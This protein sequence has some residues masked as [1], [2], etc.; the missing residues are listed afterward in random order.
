MKNSKIVILFFLVVLNLVFSNLLAQSQQGVLMQTKEKTM[1]VKQFEKKS[2]LDSNSIKDYYPVSLDLETLTKGNGNKLKIA[3][4]QLTIEGKQKKKLHARCIGI[5]GKIKGDPLGSVIISIR[6]KNVMGAIYTGGKT[7]LIK[8]L[9]EDEYYLVEP[10]FCG[11]EEG[12]QNCVLKSDIGNEKRILTPMAQESMPGSTLSVNCKLRFLIMYTPAVLEDNSD[13]YNFI[14]TLFFQAQNAL[15]LS[16]ISGGEWEL[17]YAGL[18]QY[19]EVNDPSIS[20]GRF[21]DRDRFVNNNDGYMDEVHVLRQKYNAD[22]CVLMT[23]CQYPGKCGGVAKTIAATSANVAFCLVHDIMDAVAFRH[24]V[25]HLLGGRHE[26]DGSTYPYAYSHGYK[27]TAAGI[28]HQTIMATGA[29]TTNNWSNP[30][31]LNNGVPMGTYSWN[32]CARVLDQT[33]PY[34]AKFLQP[35]S[36]LTFSTDSEIGDL[37]IGD[38]IS[39]NKVTISNVTLPMDAD[40]KIHAFETTISQDFYVELGAELEIL[41]DPVDDCY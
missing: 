35:E 24:E 41:N 19:V 10:T 21:I 6:D 32:D 40:V 31:V 17:A 37:I 18:T 20:D 8:T 34:E 11:L 13:I 33:I 38:I 15:L 16:E 23:K 27:Y 39:D 25:G 14:T 2:K 28:P 5:S 12:F 26:N 9:G 1:N 3:D 7:Y 36:D 29:P 30:D 22:I 4:L